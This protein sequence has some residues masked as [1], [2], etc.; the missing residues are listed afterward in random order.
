MSKVQ[1]VSSILRVGFALSKWPHLHRAYVVTVPFILILAVYVLREFPIFLF[2]KSVLVQNIY[3]TSKIMHFFFPKSMWQIKKIYLSNLCRYFKCETW[4]SL[5][6]C[7]THRI[8]YLL[9][10][11]WHCR[12][13][14]DKLTSNCCLFS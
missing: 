10:R 9:L 13:P 1:E 2:T 5:F 4:N 7:T 8:L 14:N 11:I 12:L 3:L 6:Q